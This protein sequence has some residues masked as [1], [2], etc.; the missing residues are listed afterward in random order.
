MIRLIKKAKKLMGKRSY[1]FDIAI[2]H[3]TEV[4]QKQRFQAKIL[5]FSTYPKKT[6][7]VNFMIVL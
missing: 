7:F 6:P 1:S 4:H 3:G 5:R 2:F